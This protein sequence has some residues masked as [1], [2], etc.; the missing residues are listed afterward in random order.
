MESICNEV[1]IKPENFYHKMSICY[2]ITIITSMIETNVV[3]KLVIIS[4]EI[5]MDV[6]QNT[7][8]RWQM[9]VENIQNIKIGDL[10]ENPATVWV[11]L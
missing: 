11:L 4:A 9:V 1:D 7:K 10:I 3:E 5:E 6:L 8:V 2:Y